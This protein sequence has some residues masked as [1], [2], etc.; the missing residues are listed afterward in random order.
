MPAKRGSAG[1]SS[2]RAHKQQ[3]DTS[4]DSSSKEDGSKKTEPSEAEEATQ[5]VSGKY[6]FF[7][8]TGGFKRHFMSLLRTGL[9]EPG[10]H[11]N[12]PCMEVERR[13][14]VGGSV[15]HILGYISKVAEI[16]LHSKNLKTVL[17][18]ILIQKTEEVVA[19]P[20][21]KLCKDPGM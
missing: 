3:E 10:S 18:G 13:G 15:P 17:G 14:F 11:R 12:R 4:R 2:R 7:W 6:N 9:L 19:H 16:C 21:N 5:E 20:A 1:G 8:T